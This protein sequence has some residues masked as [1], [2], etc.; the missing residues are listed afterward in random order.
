[1]DMCVV[2]LMDSDIMK[3]LYIY[4]KI[5]QAFVEEEAELSGII[6]FRCYTYCKNVKNVI[7]QNNILKIHN[8][9]EER[10]SSCCL[11]ERC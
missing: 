6:A 1:M 2:V 7:F 3:L 4:R 10:L 5:R 8:Y 11:S 9:T